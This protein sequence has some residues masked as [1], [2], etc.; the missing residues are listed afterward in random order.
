[1]IALSQRDLPYI[2]LTVDPIL[3]AYRTDKR[4]RRRA[5][6]PEARTATSSATR[7]RYAPWLDFA[8][9][10][11][12]RGRR[13]RMSDGGSSGLMYRADRGRGASCSRVGALIVSAGGAADREAIEV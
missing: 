9:A 10:E 6:V 1:M 2:V 7:S 8:P 3:Q 12:G 13:R 4:R 11:R 5:V